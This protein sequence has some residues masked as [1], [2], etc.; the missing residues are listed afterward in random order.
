MTKSIE[1]QAKE[2]YKS[3]PWQFVNNQSFQS[4]HNNAFIAGAKARDAEWIKV[5]NEL[6][7]LMY[8]NP[9]VRQDAYNQGVRDCIRRF[10]KAELMMKDLV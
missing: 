3:I 1:E 10:A 8:T 2:N 7:S 9:N 4:V 5:V 6:E